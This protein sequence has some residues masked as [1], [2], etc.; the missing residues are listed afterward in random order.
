MQAPSECKRVF[1]SIEIF[2]KCSSDFSSPPGT[3]SL[4]A[5]AVFF[6]NLNMG[7]QCFE[8]TVVCLALSLVSKQKMQPVAEGLERDDL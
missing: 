8:N 5:A 1:L 2:H 6:L 3:P 7:F 4:C